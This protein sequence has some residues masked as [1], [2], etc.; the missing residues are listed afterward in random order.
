MASDRSE[1][2]VGLRDVPLRVDE[3]DR[4]AAARYHDQAFYDMEVE[5]FWPHVW[6]MA[7]RLEEIPE[8]GD[9]VE[10]SNVGQS[11]IVVRNAEGGV[12]AFHNACR[13]RGVQLAQDRGNVRSG[14][15][16]PF[17]G[18]CYDLEGAN[19]FVYSPDHFRDENIDPAELNLRPC[20]VETW[21][22]SAYINHDDDAAPLRE[23]LEP[24]ATAMDAFNAHE[25]R[26]E[27]SESCI[28]PVNWRLA[29]GA[30]LEGYHVRTTHPELIPKGTRDKHSYAPSRPGVDYASRYAGTADARTQVDNF[31]FYLRNLNVGN[32]GMIDARELAIAESLRDVDLTGSQN[33]SRDFTH[34][35]YAALTEWSQETGVPMPDFDHIVE[36]DIPN[37]TW[38]AFP[39]VFLQ[40]IFGSAPLYR[41]RPLGPEE[42]LFDIWTMT[43]YAPGEA[44]PT[45]PTPIPM[46]PDD[47]R[48]PL[49]PSQDFSNLPKQQ[50]GLHAGGFE[51]M[52]LAQGVEGMISNVERLVD[53]Y[54]AGADPDRLSRAAKHVSGRVGHV[55]MHP[56]EVLDLGT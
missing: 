51:Y 32:K 36:N 31:L 25:M 3:P 14:F 24:F 56:A 28:L 11:V 15:V 21:G 40:P 43:P 54:L 42:T 23:S 46:A 9:F 18:W 26:I 22:G 41:V 10:Y 7:C 49:I 35:I 16:C 55:D 50:I 4:I 8:A 39:N 19:T 38:F 44:P 45:P 33:V 52:R 13:H 29:L 20:R 34:K 17:H 37:G 48:W 12:N 6:Q 53:G 47:P 27:W 1:T 30:F 5:H 2:P